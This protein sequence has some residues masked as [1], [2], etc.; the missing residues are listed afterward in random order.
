MDRWSR[1]VRMEKEGM[2]R[3]R[4]KKRLNIYKRLGGIKRGRNEG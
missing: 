2:M 4:E 1:K 3:E